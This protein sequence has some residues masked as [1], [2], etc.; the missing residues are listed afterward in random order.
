MRKNDSMN[1]MGMRKLRLNKNRVHQFNS[2]GG[3][4]TQPSIQL[5][6]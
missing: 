6:K 1:M 3:R 5:V 2:V 4:Q